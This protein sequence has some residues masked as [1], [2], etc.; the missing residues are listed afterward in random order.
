L[1]VRWYFFIVRLPNRPFGGISASELEFLNHYYRAEVAL[2]LGDQSLFEQQS[3]RARRQA[4]AMS[5]NDSSLLLLASLMY[6]AGKKDETK[7][8]YGILFRNYSQE[9]EKDEPFAFDFNKMLFGSGRK[10]HAQIVAL[11]MS[12]EESRTAIES[13]WKRKSARLVVAPLFGAVVR[14]SNP[15]WA[16]EMYLQE[17]DV[18]FKADLACNY[19]MA[20]AN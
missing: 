8:L 16:E 14:R 13:L 11:C 15:A 19:L 12:E 6:R 7:A 18:Q 9:R 10:S 2:E 5:G 17:E 20:V 4:E 1:W 3:Q